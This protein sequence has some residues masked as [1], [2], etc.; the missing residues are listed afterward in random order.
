MLNYK[1]KRPQDWANLKLGYGV[2]KLK[3]RL[4]QTRKISYMTQGHYLNNI[5]GS[6]DIA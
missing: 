6:L 2:S 1:I 3:L 5:W 4:K